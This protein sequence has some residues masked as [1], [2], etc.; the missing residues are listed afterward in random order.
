M[1][2]FVLDKNKNPLMPC[3]EKRARKLLTKKEAVIHKRVP[4]TIR[5][6]DRVLSESTVDPL[7]IKIDPGSRYTGIALVKTKE[8]DVHVISLM[9]LQ[10]RGS[11]IKENMDT[12]TGHRRFRRNKL[13]YRPARFNNRTRAED[14]LAPSLRH[15]V[16]T[17][18]SWVD[19]I[20][21]FAPV[22][23]IV[24]ERVKFDT[25]KMMN[26]DI[27]G[28]EYQQGEL[29]GYE[30]REYI[31]EKFNR[32]CVYCDAQNVPLE[33]EHI[34]P[35]SK[36]GSN[37]ISNLTL[38]CR[39]CNQKKSNNPIQDFVKDRTRL[40][41]IMRQVKVPLKD[42]AAVNVTR[43]ILYKCLLST[44]LAVETGSGSQT[45]YNRCRLNIFKTHSLD[46]VCVGNI[47]DV[48][49]DIQYV[50]HI[51]SR[52]HGSRSLLTL[53]KYGFPRGTAQGKPGGRISQIKNHKGFQSGNLVSVYIPETEKNK[54]AGANMTGRMTWD[55]FGKNIR[56]NGLRGI[57]IKYC[58]NI[59]RSD[60]YEYMQQKLEKKD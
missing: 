18:M 16:E 60:G 33:I 4:F 52:G 56:I 9:E 34:Q 19:K 42:S 25:Q 27:S 41:R 51:Q 49:N 23:S 28:I 54:N 39:P 40:E 5:L 44:G 38:S 36:G 32:Q 31:L 53:D 11:Q 3:S 30:V 20:R 1:S 8:M 59:Q 13:R 45:K 7:Q 29:A 50:L 57:S 47:G 12:R 15:R 35:R 21:N 6:K 17:T 48:Y 22:G 43:N 2:V 37:R 24:V 58:V 55:S 14:W 46:A 26:P 10:H